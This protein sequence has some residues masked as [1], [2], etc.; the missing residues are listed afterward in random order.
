MKNQH[1]A[2]A[3]GLKNIDD[4]NGI[5]VSRTIGGSQNWFGCGYIDKSGTTL[6]HENVNFPFYSMVFIIEG[7]GT[8]V[9]HEGK[10]IELSAGTIFHRIPEHV[11]TTSINNTLPWREFYL[12]CNRE[13]FERLSLMLN[14][15]VHQPVVGRITPIFYE[16]SFKSLIQTIDH[17]TGGD[18]FNAYLQ[19]LSL[20]NDAIRES[21]RER[22]SKFFSPDQ[23]A[24]DFEYLYKNRFELRIYCKDKGIEYEVFRKLFKLDFGVSPQQYLIRRRMDEACKLLQ[25]KGLTIQQISFEL[26]YVSPYEFS[27]HFKRYYNMSPKKYRIVKSVDSGGTY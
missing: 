2:Q 19:F 1:A 18:V 22:H 6:D 14:I 11:H 15:N 5:N 8:Y 17:S 16:H 20:L 7:E 3:K 12:D 23:I 25:L 13:L 4:V 21:K 26:G 24:K 27:K 10:R 9:D